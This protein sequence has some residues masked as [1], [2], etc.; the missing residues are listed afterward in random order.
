M[1]PCQTCKKNSFFLAL[2]QFPHNGEI[3]QYLV[4]EIDRFSEVILII[5]DGQFVKNLAKRYQE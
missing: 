2:V 3:R 5:Q 4:I 1:E